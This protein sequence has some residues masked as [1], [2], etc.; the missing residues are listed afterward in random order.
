MPAP[1][2][3]LPITTGVW[4]C[5]LSLLLIMSFQAEEGGRSMEPVAMPLHST[6]IPD[7]KHQKAKNVFWLLQ[8]SS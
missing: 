7:S 5:E 8:D 3:S 6:E 2:V 4:K 1:S